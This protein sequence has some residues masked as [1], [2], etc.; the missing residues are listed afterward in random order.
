MRVCVIG[1]GIVGLST[2]AVLQEQGAD[3][4]VI[5]GGAHPGCGASAANG[6]QLSYSYVQP[7]AEPSVWGMLPGLLLRPNSPLAW[8]PSLSPG[9]WRWCWQ[10]LAA[11]RAQSARASTSALLKLAAVSCEEFAAWREKTT[12]ADIDYAQPGKLVLHS[13][14]A[15]L[16]AAE[17][18]CRTRAALAFGQRVVGRAECE[19]LEPALSGRLAGYAGATLTPGDCV[20]DCEKLVHRL[21]LDLQARG[22]TLRW[23]ERVSQF[24]RSGTRVLAALTQRGDVQA[25]A[26]VLAAGVGASALGRQLGLDLPI[27]GLKGYSVTLSAGDGRELP[28]MSVTDQARKVVYARL[29]HRLRVAGFVEVGARDTRVGAARVRSLLDSAHRLWGKVHEPHLVQHAWAGLRPATPHG[30]PIIGRT[31]LSNLFLNVGHGA[32]GLTLAFGAAR[33]LQRVMVTSR[34]AVELEPLFALSAS[35]ARGN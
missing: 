7:L 8:R 16:R 4:T 29:G 12:A 20:V 18:C 11:C 17:A 35:D 9:H 19:A 32:F 27:L 13:T 3:V 23:G 28:R 15:S 26:F 25:D 6:A 34:A 1:G 31:P 30:R 24:Q 14:P 5:D 33:L 22:A 2:A 21:A 10:F